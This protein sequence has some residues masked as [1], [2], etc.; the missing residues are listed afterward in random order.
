M[1]YSAV[2]SHRGI[3]CSS[4]FH[5][6]NK[7]WGRGKRAGKNTHI[8]PSIC[9][10]HPLLRHCYP[11]PFL[12]PGGL[13]TQAGSLSVHELLLA[14]HSEFPGVHNLSSGPAP[15]GHPESA[16]GL[17]AWTQHQ[18]G[19]LQS[20]PR[21]W[22]S[23]SFSLSLLLLDP[24]KPLGGWKQGP[25]LRVPGGSHALVPLPKPLT[26]LAAHLALRPPVL[27]LMAF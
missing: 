10:W 23:I 3:I 17:S 22:G 12:V 11:T 19:F 21:P 20:W 14:W 25:F 16:R 18:P 1:C 15:P 8:P 9:C 2:N 26:A 13:S 27:S 6:F 7:W 4:N 5:T 24:Q